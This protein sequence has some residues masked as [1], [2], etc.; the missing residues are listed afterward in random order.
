MR[1]SLHKPHHDEIWEL[2]PWL[3]NERLSERDQERVEQHVA[4]CEA[5]QAEVRAQRKLREFV[6]LDD[7]V[8]VVPNASLRKLWARIDAG[9]KGPDDKSVVMAAPVATLKRPLGMTRTRWLMAAM[10]VQAVALGVLGTAFIGRMR[11][12]EFVTLTSGPTVPADTLARV[13]FAPETTLA[14]VQGIL[15]RCHL[16]FIDGP[17][18]FG[19]YAVSALAN[20]GDAQT[21]HSIHPADDAARC[22]RDST[23]VRFAEPRQR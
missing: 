18:D 13:V 23:A 14:E 5:C 20:A 16:K 15:A 3:V 2:L 11:A 17:T 22:L 19:V 6:M 1:G 8:E 21:G 12:P 7:N 9:E 4:E 10:I